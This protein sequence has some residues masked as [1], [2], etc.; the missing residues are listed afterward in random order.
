[1]NRLAKNGKFIDA[2]SMKDTGAVKETLEDEEEVEELLDGAM[3]GV[4]EDEEV[5]F[6]FLRGFTVG[7]LRFPDS[8]PE[9]IN[10]TRTGG[11][12]GNANE[13]PE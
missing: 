7:L 6:G 11:G 2:V 8:T 3:E 12:A 9:P 13:T 10:G 1:M 5:V 4:I